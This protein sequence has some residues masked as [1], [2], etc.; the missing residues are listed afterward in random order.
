[1]AAE[2]ERLP[3]WEARVQ[4]TTALLGDSTAHAPAALAAAAESFYRK[5][6]VAD[7]YRPAARLAAPVV[8]FSARDN[9]VTLGDDYGLRDVCAGPLETHQLPGN[10]RSILAGDAARTIAERVSALLQEQ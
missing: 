5:L 4:R 10:H 2:L 9:Y 8:L 3:S 6:V 1:M 7:A